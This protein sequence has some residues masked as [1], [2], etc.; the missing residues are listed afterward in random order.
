M[1]FA[2]Y[3]SLADIVKGQPN[4]LEEDEMSYILASILLGIC[5]LHDNRIIHRVKKLEGY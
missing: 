3:G 1:E 4:T 2:H 5:Y